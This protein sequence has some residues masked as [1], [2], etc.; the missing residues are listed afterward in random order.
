MNYKLYLSLLSAL[1]TSLFF[2]ACSGEEPV[3]QPADQPVEIAFSMDNYA[4]VVTSARSVSTATTRATDTGSDAERE[5]GNLYLFLFDNTG[6]NPVKYYIN[7]ATFSGGTYIASENRI[8]LNMTQTEAGTRQVYIVANVDATLKS[9]LDGVTTVSGTG[10]TAL[11]TVL[12][13]TPT[14]WSPTLTTPLLMSGNKTH[15]FISTDRVLGSGGTNTRVHL[16]R[17]LAKVEVNITLRQEHQSNPVVLE[18]DFTGDPGT[19]TEKHQ[20]HYAFLNFDKNT[21]VIK[22]ATVTKQSELTAPDATVDL[23]SL[24]ESAWIVWNSLGTYV[25]GSNGTVTELK[26][27]TYINERDEEA[28]KPLS[29]IGINMPYEGDYPPPQFG[30]DITQIFLPKTILRNHWYVYDIEL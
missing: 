5:I 21:Y 23:H 13:T 12:R 7:D 24:G 17:A 30:P 22:P 9:A 8:R 11:Q 29:S 20:Y 4:K 19:L 14:P 1:W 2:T 28:S 15:D 25:Q 27:V 3:P 18:G 26:L 6:A 16:T 10:A